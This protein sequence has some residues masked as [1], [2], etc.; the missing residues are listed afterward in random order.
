MTVFSLPSYTHILDLFL[1]MYLLPI[2][3]IVFYFYKSKR[4]GFLYFFTIICFLL[5]FLNFPFLKIFFEKRIFLTIF[6]SVFWYVTV[7]ICIVLLFIYKLKP[8]ILKDRLLDLWWIVFSYVGVLGSLILT[9]LIH[10][11]RL[12]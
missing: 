7:F 3:V 8:E 6:N 1:R 12:E 9:L 11:A 2:L 5:N 4:L 10:F